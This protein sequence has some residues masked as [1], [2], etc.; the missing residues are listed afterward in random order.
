[1]PD[2]LRAFDLVPVPLS[3]LHDWLEARG[4][5]VCEHS[6]KWGERIVVEV[7]GNDD[8]TDLAVPVLG[9]NVCVPGVHALGN[10]STGR[11]LS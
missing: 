10:D 2:P 11:V 5:V 8:H 7:T 1:M 3:E 6:V 9:G 4:L